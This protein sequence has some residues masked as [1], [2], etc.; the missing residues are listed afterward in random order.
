M[1]CVSA[2][3]SAHISRLLVYSTV[4]LIIQQQA[5]QQR[6]DAAAAQLEVQSH[7]DAVASAQQQAADVQAALDTAAATIANDQVRTDI[8]SNSLFS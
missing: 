8:D 1:S 3:P 2:V 7:T 5:Q 4:L 6:S